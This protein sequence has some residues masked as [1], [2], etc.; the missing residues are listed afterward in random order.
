MVGSL[1][2]ECK[3]LRQRLQEAILFPDTSAV[4]DYQA[5]N[6]EGASFWKDRFQKDELNASA[7]RYESFY[8]SWARFVHEVETSFVLK[9]IPTGIFETGNIDLVREQGSRYCIDQNG[10]RRLSTIRPLW[11]P[12]LRSALDPMHKGYVKPRD[13]FSLLHDSSLSDTLRRLTLQNAGYGVLVECE[14]APGDLPLPAAIESPSDH[15]GW[16]SAQIVAVPRPDEL[17]IFSEREVMESSG[18]A[19]FAHFNDITQDVKVYVRYLQTGQIERKS[20][21][22]QVRPIG[23]I[24]VGAIL[25]IR[26]EL[27]SGDHAWSCDLHITEFKA[28]YGGEYIITVDGGANA[29]VFSTRPLKNSF[30]KMLGDDNNSSSSTIPEFDCTL[31]GPSKVFIDP[32][33]VG[34]KIQVE[35]D[36][37]WYDSRVTVVDG[38][39]IEYIDW[40][41]LPKQVP[42]NITEAQGDSERDENDGG[43]FAFSE[44][45]LR[46]LGKGTRRLWRPWR[47]NIRRYDVRPHRCFHIGDSVEAPIMYPDFRLHYHVTDNSQLY[48]PARIVDVQGDQYVVEFSPALSSHEWWPGRIPK[49]TQIDL[50]PGSGVTVENPLD[51]N[52]VTLHMDRVRPFSAGPRPVLGIQSA[53]PSGWSSF[54]GVH[55]SNLEDLLE[56]SLW[57][58]GRDSPRTGSQ[59][60]WRAFEDEK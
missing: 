46:Q 8:V 34:E 30:D 59:R 36:G 56:R 32:P 5:Q 37:F 14:R 17:G 31:L 42:T 25:S 55:L 13:Y 9:R 41:S 51:F 57:S 1:I 49:G 4:Q 24:S 6:P 21:L 45:Q 3:Q 11:L 44:E 33:K 19:L 10:T 23:G 18:D 35:Y 26:H 2:K 43:S 7:L 38:D 40:D 60:N 20:L 28:C 54:Q 16:I 50:V 22:K 29:I 12:A 39:E 48:L 52:R 27:E 53:K 58:S 47:R 15:V